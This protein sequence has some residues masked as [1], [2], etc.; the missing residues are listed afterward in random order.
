MS[1][2]SYTYKQHHIVDPDGYG[3]T[4]VVTDLSGMVV[5]EGYFCSIKHA[6]AAV[7]DLFEA[8]GRG[9]SFESLQALRERCN[10]NSLAMFDALT[11][12]KDLSSPGQAISHDDAMTIL[13]EI[14]Q[15]TK[16]LMKGMN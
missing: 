1:R 13:A 16:V 2:S 8:K 5:I 7:D 11:A 6:M 10:K 14:H 3:D 15:H 4:F 12:I 9:V